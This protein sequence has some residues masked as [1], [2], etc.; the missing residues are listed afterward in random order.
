MQTL[1]GH[2]VKVCKIVVGNGDGLT[3]GGE[4]KFGTSNSAASIGI[5]ATE[6]ATDLTD[7]T[8]GTKVCGD[9]EVK[10]GP[11]SIFEWGSP[12]CPDLERRRHWVPHGPGQAFRRAHHCDLSTNGTVN[13]DDN[14][15][16]VTFCNK[17]IPITKNVTFSK[18]ICKTYADV[19]NNEGPGGQDDIGQQ[20]DPSKTHADLGANGPAG[21]NDAVTPAND[22][23]GDCVLAT[24]PWTFNL[25]TTNRENGSGG[26]SLGSVVVPAGSLS[27]QL[28]AAQLAETMKGSGLYVEEVY[29]AGF[30]FGSIKCYTDHLNDDNWEWLNFSGGIPV[31]EVHCIAYNVP[32]RDRH[33]DRQALRQ[34]QWLPGHRR[35][36][37]GVQHFTPTTDVVCGAPVWN[38]NVATITCSVPYDWA[39]SVTETP[40]PYWIQDGMQPV[41]AALGRDVPRSRGHRYRMGLLQLPGRRD[42]KFRRTTWSL[43]TTQESRRTTIGTSRSPVR[44]PT[45]SRTPSLSVVA[46]ST[47]RSSHSATDIPQSRMMAMSDSARRSATSTATATKRLLSLVAPQT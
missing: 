23:E 8:L 10:A 40:K 43:R 2:T 31:G 42:S 1:C 12:A 11:Q 16:E 46:R 27:V 36:P 7:G 38:G 33:H 26:S 45:T 39:G 13:I 25:W 20:A 35:R 19:P 3:M 44:T 4:F 15:T 41:G 37:A 6:P 18:Y 28:T 22:N 32:A 21:N 30:G 47:S 14:T 24:T 5:T 34:H 29:Q 9:L 17:T